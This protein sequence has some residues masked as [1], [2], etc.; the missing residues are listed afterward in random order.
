MSANGVPILAAS[1]IRAALHAEDM[2]TAMG[3]IATHERDV[4]A[5]LG[6]AA[7][8][9]H[10]ESSWQALLTEQ[11]VLLRELQAARSDAADAMQRLN[12]N[13][14]SVQAYQSGSEK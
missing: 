10:D 3:L 8:C 1:A 4:R 7:I 6:D 5:A 2:D 14:R 9:V 11:S 13:R 12:G